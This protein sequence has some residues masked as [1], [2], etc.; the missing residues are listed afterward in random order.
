M[1]KYL[2]IIGMISRSKFKGVVTF[3]FEFEYPGIEENSA[4]RSCGVPSSCLKTLC[5]SR[6][7]MNVS[8]P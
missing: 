3:E 2:L 1:A 6:K 7:P 8:D 5:A 4:K